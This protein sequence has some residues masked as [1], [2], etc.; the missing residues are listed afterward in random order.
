MITISVLDDGDGIAPDVAKRIFEP[1]FT[2]KAPGS[3]YGLGLAVCQ[4]II[5]ESGGRIEVTSGAGMSSGPGTISTHSRG[6][7]FTVL[8]PCHPP[9]MS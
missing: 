9:E 4:R 6:A 7:C 2:T 8:L 1:F 5:D 3:G